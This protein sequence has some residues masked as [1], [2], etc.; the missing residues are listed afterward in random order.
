MQA[1]SLPAE[2][3][4]KPKNTRVG[5]LS[6]LQQGLLHCTRI[7][8]QLSYFPIVLIILDLYTN[9]SFQCPVCVHVC[10][11][12]H[13]IVCFLPVGTSITLEE[14]RATGS[15]ILAWKIPWTEEPGGLQSTGSERVGHD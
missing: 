5:S 8:Y 6:L 15:S 11:C 12:M 13:T 7:L 14:E 1:D 2:P 4:G 3:L 10:A 9:P